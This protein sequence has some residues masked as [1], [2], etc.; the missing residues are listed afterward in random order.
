MKSTLSTKT[1]LFVNWKLLL[2]LLLIFIIASVLVFMFTSAR[3]DRLGSLEES[4]LEEVRKEKRRSSF[5]AI[6]G[7]LVSGGALVVVLSLM[8]YRWKSAKAKQPLRDITPVR[9]SSPKHTTSTRV[10]TKRESDKARTLAKTTPR[11]SSTLPKSIKAKTVSVPP[12]TEAQTKSPKTDTVLSKES[13]RNLSDPDL[14][15]ELPKPTEEPQP[16]QQLAEAKKG[17]ETK[18]ETIVTIAAPTVETPKAETEPEPEKIKI[19]PQTLDKLENTAAIHPHYPCKIDPET[20]IADQAS[21][22]EFFSRFFPTDG[23]PQD[24]LPSKVQIMRFKIILSIVARDAL[25]RIIHGNVLYAHFL[26]LM[27]QLAA[28]SKAL[29]EKGA[30]F[31]E[32]NC[33]KITLSDDK[34][35]TET[36]VLEHLYG[37]AAHLKMIVDG[38]ESAKISDAAMSGCREIMKK[39]IIDPM[40]ALEAIQKMGKFEPQR[41]AW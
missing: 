27:Q 32:Y 35:M 17:A 19:T 2:A 21:G 41:F 5:R 26:A 3:N 29:I 10:Q 30:P 38:Y 8:V 18:S 33:K 4:K 11:S 34:G 31:Y 36:K 40:Q 7:I 16:L 12:S 15:P 1:S 39:Q 13:Q 28:Q 20:I 24:Q 6:I 22:K 37:V 25:A 14:V 9:T 23:Q